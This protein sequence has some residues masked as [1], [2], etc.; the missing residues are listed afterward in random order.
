MA[1]STSSPLG[2]LSNKVAIVT[3]SSSGIGRA[4]ALAYFREG[5]KVVC[6]DIRPSAR[7]EVDHETLATTLEIL[8]NE[9]DKDRSIFVLTDVSN[10]KDVETLVEQAAKHFGRL[11]M[12]VSLPRVLLEPLTT[13]TMCLQNCQQ[14]RYCSSAFCDTRDIGR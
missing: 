10:R 13:P 5:A 1:S 7:P 2:R 3:G 4:I 8:Q 11:D 14:C 12:Y 9:G 6:A